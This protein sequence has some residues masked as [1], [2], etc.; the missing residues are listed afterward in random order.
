MSANPASTRP[1]ARLVLMAAALLMVL[2]RL[3]VDSDDRAGGDRN[4]AQ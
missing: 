4:G 2:F 3:L 1:F